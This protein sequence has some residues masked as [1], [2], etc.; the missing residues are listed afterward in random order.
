MCFCFSVQY[1][2][3]KRKCNNYEGGNENHTIFWFISK[4][5]FVIITFCA[6][7]ISTYSTTP[8]ELFCPWKNRC[9]VFQMTVIDLKHPIYIKINTNNPVIY[10]NLHYHQKHSFGNIMWK[11]DT[12]WTI[13]NRFCVSLKLHASN[14]HISCCTSN[15]LLWTELRVL[16]H[17]MLR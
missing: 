2:V 11:F 4:E 14:R 8:S 15:T 12:N 16:A 10:K 3:S 17:W 5:I 6:E 9:K 7:V 1:R 13:H